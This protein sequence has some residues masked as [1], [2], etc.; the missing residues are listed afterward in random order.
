MTI[1]STTTKVTYNGDGST[2]AFTVTFA[3]SAAS[4]VEVI[5][6]DSSGTETTWTNGSEYTLTAAGSSGTVTATSAPASGEKLI[7]RRITPYTQ[8]TG[9]RDTAT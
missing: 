1:G 6:R 2:V 9:E 3:Y 7:I 5:H 4:E 8:P